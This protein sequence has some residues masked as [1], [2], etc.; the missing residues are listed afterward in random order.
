MMPGDDP[1][2]HTRHTQAPS[3]L[4]RTP[5]SGFDHQF[6]GVEALVAGEAPRGDEAHGG[7]DPVEAAAAGAMDGLAVTA[8]TSQIGRK[9]AA[10]LGVDRD[11]GQWLAPLRTEREN[12]KGPSALGR[13]PGADTQ[14]VT[15]ARAGSVQL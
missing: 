2:L 4:G 15:A 7:H 11:I 14:I 1:M 8:G 6:A 13:T 10:G 5:G 12:S 9:P 3:G